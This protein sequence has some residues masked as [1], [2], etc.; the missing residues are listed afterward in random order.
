MCVALEQPVLTSFIYWPCWLEIFQNFIHKKTFLDYAWSFGLLS[1]LCSVVAI[2]CNLVWPETLLGLGISV[3]VSLASREFWW[4]FLYISK[5]KLPHSHDSLIQTIYWYMKMGLSGLMRPHCLW[6][7]C[8]QDDDLWNCV[9]DAC[10][11]I[12]VLYL[13]SDVVWVVMYQ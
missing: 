4:E 10:M 1:R 13:W 12:Y 5:E 9:A 11:C 3:L 2:Q 8:E 7:Q 6:K